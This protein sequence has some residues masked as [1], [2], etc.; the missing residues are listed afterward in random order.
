MNIGAMQDTLDVMYRTKLETSIRDLTNE[1][2]S[3]YFP[4]VSFTDEEKEGLAR[5]V[6]ESFTYQAAEYNLKREYQNFKL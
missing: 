2:L 5:Y 6:A 3:T 4:N 1:I